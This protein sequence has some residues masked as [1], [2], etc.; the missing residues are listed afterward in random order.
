MS[1]NK[2]AIITAAITGAIHIPTQTEY[3]PITPKEIADEAV[4]AYEAGAAVAHIHVRDPKDGRP[5]PN[6]ELFEEVCDSIR[7]RCNVILCL[8]TGGDPTTMTLEQRLLPVTSLKPELGSFNGGS[9]NFA[10]HP[11]AGR[12]TEYKFDWEKQY[13]LNTENNIHNNTF[14]SMREYLEAFEKCGTKPE[15]EVY[16]MGQINNIK[17]LVDTYNVKM[18]LDIQFVMGVLGGLPASVE[19][20]VRMVDTTYKTFGQ[21][22]VH[23]SV[24]GAGQ[25]QM[26]LG[27]VALAMGGNV[28]VGLEDS[29]WLSKG[30]KAKS[31]AEQ[32]A[33]IV[34]IAEELSVETATPD[35]AREMLG[36][37]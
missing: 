31:N 9:L 36:L 23:W 13:L 18:P 15:F 29:I 14:K 12:F 8:T 24:I 22:N 2:K 1:K 21:E 30:V 32:V 17:Y 34:R 3:L 5:V 11:L 26:K 7:S 35:E 6:I 16:D 33:K 25:M 10:L 4:K 28:R 20:L 19:N 27:A 37:V